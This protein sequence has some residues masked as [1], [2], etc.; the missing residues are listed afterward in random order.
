MIQKKE[1]ITEMED[2]EQ[3]HIKKKSL[4]GGGIILLG[5]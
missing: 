4:W 3:S 5:V 1:E 2:K